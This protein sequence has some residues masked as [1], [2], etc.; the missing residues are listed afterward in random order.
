MLQGIEFPKSLLTDKDSIDLPDSLGLPVE[1]LQA[2]PPLT[3]YFL[4]HIPVVLFHIG[5][6]CRRLA[7]SSTR[8]AKAPGAVAFLSSAW[9]IGASSSVIRCSILCDSS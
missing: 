2:S 8:V 3:N 7:T 1:L 4:P 9:S 6:R 5:R